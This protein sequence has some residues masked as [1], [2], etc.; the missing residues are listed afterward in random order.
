PVRAYI[1]QLLPAVL[2]GT[3]NPGKVFDR[4][5]SIEDTP[6][7]YAAM[8]APPSPQGHDQALITFIDATES[9]PQRRTSRADRPL[10]RTGVRVSPREISPVGPSRRVAGPSMGN[11]SQDVLLQREV[12]PWPVQHPP[13]ATHRVHRCRTGGGQ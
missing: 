4:T 6:Q 10:G 8:D 3:V 11:H 7:A 5:V 2:D 1:E 12:G 9:T 13:M